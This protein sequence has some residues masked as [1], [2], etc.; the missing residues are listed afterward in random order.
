MY[1]QNA[2]GTG[3]LTAHSYADV[4]SCISRTKVSYWA[5][6]KWG[7]RG[8]NLPRWATGG[9][10]YICSRGEWEGH[11]STRVFC[12]LSRGY[13]MDYNNYVQ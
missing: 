7:K 2:R 12:N 11:R 5:T 6:L 9:G 10:G 4:L 8:L 3:K 13:T 1:Y